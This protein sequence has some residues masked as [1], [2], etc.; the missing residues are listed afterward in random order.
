[1]RP[2]PLFCCLRLEKALDKLMDLPGICLEDMTREWST[3]DTALVETSIFFVWCWCFELADDIR[4][5]NSSNARDCR[6]IVDK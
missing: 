5:R 6:H 3:S 4:Q 1:M 2:D